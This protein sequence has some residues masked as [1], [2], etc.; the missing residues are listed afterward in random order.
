MRKAVQ[1]LSTVLLF[2][3]NPLLA[4]EKVITTTFNWPIPS[5]AKVTQETTKNGKTIKFSYTVNMRRKA[6]NIIVS[7]DEVNL[8]EFQGKSVDK[9]QQ[10]S[11]LLAAVFPSILVD[12]KGQ[13]IEV[14]EFDS[15]FGQLIKDIQNPNVLTA[16]KSPEMKKLFYNRA[17]ENW[18]VWACSWMNLSIPLDK[19]LVETIP[20][21]VM[22]V[23]FPE[24]WVTK[25]KSIM[26]KGTTVTNISVNSYLHFDQASIDKFMSNFVDAYDKTGAQRKPF[27]PKE[28]EAI[29][30][31]KAETTTEIFV[32]PDTFK[33]IVI[34]STS[35]TSMN[36]EGEQVQKKSE[37]TRYMFDWLN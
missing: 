24:K 12:P 22:G 21:D 25:T 11:F 3:C 20:K 36:K 31:L 7:Q 5:S 13:P 15:Y 34:I 9:A 29:K 27:D 14:I 10:D 17:F 35:T 2:L 23:S 32:Q 6:E 26:V 30:G 18:C 33:P 4:N 1:T 19:P 8:L 16:I 28:I 37:S